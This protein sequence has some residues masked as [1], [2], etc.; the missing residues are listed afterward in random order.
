MRKMIKNVA[1]VS[2]PAIAFYGYAAFAATRHDIFAYEMY[3]LFILVL[4]FVITLVAY[5]VRVYWGHVFL[6]AVGVIVM[7]ALITRLII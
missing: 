7:D 5:L 3:S 1:I 6:I 2:S 4:Y